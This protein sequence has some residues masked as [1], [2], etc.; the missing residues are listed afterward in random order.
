M[1][2]MRQFPVDLALVKSY[3]TVLVSWWGEVSWTL[4][5]KPWSWPVTLSSAF[6]QDTEKLAQFSFQIS[7]IDSSP[8]CWSCSLGTWYILFSVRQE[9][10]HFHFK[11]ALVW[12]VWN[13][14]TTTVVLSS[15][16]IT[17]WTYKVPR[18]LANNYGVDSAGYTGLRDESSP[19]TRWRRAVSD[20]INCS[21]MP[22]N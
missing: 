16:I 18:Q 4:G 10:P 22:S 17:T 14:H 2:V 20:S 6:W 12:H 9:L 11:E 15:K 3:C 5:T 8:H 21:K 13:A 19:Q 1:K 7:Q